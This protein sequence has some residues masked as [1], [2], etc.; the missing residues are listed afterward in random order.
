M[1]KLRDKINAIA[2]NPSLSNTTKRQKLNEI[3]KDNP[4]TLFIK[5]HL[6]SC[7]NMSVEVWFKTDTY[8]L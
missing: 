8:E 5:T 4:Q 3:E 6:C 7:G 2:N 1:N